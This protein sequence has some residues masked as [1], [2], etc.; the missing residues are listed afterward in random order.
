MVQADA[1]QRARADDPEYQRQLAEEAA[2]WSRPGIHSILGAVERGG[3][4]AIDRYINTRLT[5]DPDVRWYETIARN[6]AFR[7]AL[8]VGTSSLHQEGRIVEANPGAR[9]TFVDIAAGAL[10]QRQRELG[11][12]FPG[13][14]ETR[15]ADLNFAEL[16]PHAYDLI[17]SGSTLHHVVNL[18]HVAAQ[19]NRA[20]TTDG[21][22]FLQDY[23]GENGLRVPDAKRRIVE[24][25]H[26][27]DARRLGVP[28]WRVLWD[29]GEVYSPFEAVRSEDTLRVLREHLVERQ[30]RAC[31]AVAGALLHVRGT[32]PPR[33]RP[34]RDRRIVTLSRKARARL[35][36]RPLPRAVTPFQR[37]VIVADELFGDAGLLANVNAFAIYRK[38]ADGE[39]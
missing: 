39:S 8:I 7:R 15:T 38:R 9:F 20:L 2:F 37:D 3:E 1:T 6:G 17:V 31:G 18:E 22:F 24:S 16:E 27:R 35:A 36:G 32:D 29:D 5:G 4:S 13:R 23:V 14:I 33:P 28:A 19:L 30:V 26:A 11:A 34:L 12:R 25:L 10:E 21:W